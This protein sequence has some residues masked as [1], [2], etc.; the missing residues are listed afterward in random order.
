MQLNL[1][2]INIT[3]NNNEEIVNVLQR[4]RKELNFLLMN[5]DLDN[6]PNVANK[7]TDINGNMSLIQQDIDSILLTVQNAQGDIAAL[8]I[9]ADSIQSQVSDAQGNISNLIQT[10]NLIAS[11]VQ[12]LQGNVSTLSQTATSLTTRISNAEGSI[13]TLS[14]TATSLTSRISNAEGSISSLSQTV[15]GISITVQGKTSISEVVSYLSVTQSGIKIASQNIDL[16][17]ITT[18]YA[19]GSTTSYIMCNGSNMVMYYN[20]SE[21]FRIQIDSI[22]G[23][24]IYSSYGPLFFMGNIDF[25]QATSVNGLTVSFA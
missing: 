19:A 5:L 20:D 25:S 3:G 6:M 2:N 8:Q 15:N 18:L 11:Q 10:S 12:D 16:T 23:T 13:S 4:Y 21:F 17:G 7:L 1:P 22:F 14:Q 24:D 9:T